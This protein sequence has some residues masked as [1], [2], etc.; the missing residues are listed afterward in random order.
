MAESALGVIKRIEK[1][2]SIVQGTN[3]SGVVTELKL[4]SQKMADELKLVRQEVA[5]ELKL[6]RL[7]MTAE[8]GSTRRLLKW[9]LGILGSLLAINGYLQIAG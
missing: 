2:E 7:E 5:G 3:G 4:L 6:V 1:L 8:S 9:V